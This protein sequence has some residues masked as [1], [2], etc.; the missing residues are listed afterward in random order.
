MGIISASISKLGKDYKIGEHFRLR[1]MACKDGSDKVLYSTELIAKL[2]RLREYGGFTITI[3]SGYRTASYNK[4]IG[5]ASKSQHTLG[6]AADI[7]VYKDGKVVNARKICCI[8]QTLGF[9]GIGFISE[10]ATHVDMRTSGSYRGDE[11]KGY[12]GNV[13]GNFYKYFGISESTIKAMKVTNKTNTTVKSED[14]EVLDQAQFNKMMDTY[15]AERGQEEPSD[16]SKDARE[17]AEKKG[18]IKGTD[19]GMEYQSFVTREQLVT[20]LNRMKK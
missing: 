19:V 11:R 15:L 13:G 17:W 20:M 5:G 10:N 9:K 6:T 4:K 14:N 7:V 18:I 8:C 12:S 16:W 2:E 3:N 1:E